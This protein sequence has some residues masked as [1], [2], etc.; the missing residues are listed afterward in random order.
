MPR[1]RMMK[2][3]AERMAAQAKIVGIRSAV[4]GKTVKDAPYSATEITESNQ[5]LADGTR[6]HNETTAQVY[7]DSEGRTRRETPNEVTI[8]DPVAQGQL[9]PEP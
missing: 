7:R 9:H 1:S 4:I 2:I 6:I 3:E 5:M 8:W